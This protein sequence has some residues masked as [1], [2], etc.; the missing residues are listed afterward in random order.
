MSVI[1]RLYF[2]LILPPEM[3]SVQR[4][5]PWNF[6]NKEGGRKS[7]QQN[8]SR[9]VNFLSA[10]MDG[11]LRI[12]ARLWRHERWNRSTRRN[13]IL[14][15]CFSRDFALPQIETSFCLSFIFVSIR[16]T[17][18]NRLHTF[19]NS[20]AFYFKKGHYVSVLY[21]R[22]YLLHYVVIDCSTCRHC[23]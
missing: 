8:F 12:E 22:L 13:Y 23:R 15:R 14:R 10:A 20:N 2:K 4:A 5:K 1:Y 16:N 7:K 9:G 6:N 3:V 11:L 19:E 18:R 21:C 17:V